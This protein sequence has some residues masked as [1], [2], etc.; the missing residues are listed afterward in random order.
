MFVL[1]ASQCLNNLSINSIIAGL[2]SIRGVLVIV[3]YIGVRQ[4]FCLC[5]KPVVSFDTFLQGGSIALCVV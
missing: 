1:N 4:S 2:L 3:S 5:I